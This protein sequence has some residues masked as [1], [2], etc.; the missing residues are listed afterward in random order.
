MLRICVLE[1]PS[2]QLFHMKALSILGLL[3][4]FT[5]SSFSAAAVTHYVDL[6]N[7]TPISPYTSWDTAATNI[8]HAI[9]IAVAGDLVLVTNGVYSSGTRAVYGLLL[10][11]V[12]IGKQVTVQ[13]VNGPEVTSI[14]AGYISS[15][16]RYVRGV[17]LGNGAVLSG[18][19]ISGGWATDG[20]P[21]GGDPVQEESGGGVLCEAAG[22]IVTNCIF[23]ENRAGNSGGAVYG[24]T[25]F[26]SLF[27]QNSASSGGGVYG[28]RVSD[29]LF[30]S[31]RVSASNSG[32]AAYGS[33]LTNCL[34]QANTAGR[35]A[36][37]YSS[38]FSNC[39][40][41][42]NIASISGGGAYLGSLL[43]CAVYGNSAGVSGGG[44]Y[45][46]V[47]TNC[48]IVSNVASNSAGGAY[49][50]QLKNSILYFNSAPS[51]ANYF[52]GSF[53]S[54]CTVPF[55]AAGLNNFTN[56]PQL[57][58]FTSLSSASPCIGAGDSSYARGTD[59]DGEEWLNP[60]S[61][62]CNEFNSGSL[63]GAVAVAINVNL[64]N[65]TIGHSVNFQA[66]IDGRVNAHFW[67]FGD[68]T[69]ISNSINNIH[70]WTSAGDFLVRLVA[71]NESNPLGV[72]SSVL[73]QVSSP[74]I[75]YVALNSAYP[76][77]PFTS[78]ATAATNIQ[79]AI[80]A[81]PHG[82][83]SVVVVSNGIYEFGARAVYGTMSNRVAVTKP[84]TVTSING[85]SVTIIRGIQVTGS[86]NGNTAIR[87]VYL[88]NGASLSG[89][90][91]TSGGTRAGGDLV[92]EQ[93]GGGLWMESTNVLVT[94][95]VI[96]GNSAA[97]FGGGAY[98]GHLSNCSLLENTGSLGGGA[99]SNLLENCFL[100]R[101]SAGSGGAVYSGTLKNCTVTGNYASTGGGINNCTAN[102]CIIYYNDALSGSD[103]V[104]GTLNYSCV[105][106]LPT[107]GVGNITSEPE[108]ASSS[109][110]S[111]KSPCRNAGT[112]A[113]AA[114]TDIDSQ[115]WADPPTM[116]CDEFYGGD[117]VGPL[118]LYLKAGFTNCAAGF[119]IGFVGDVMGNVSASRWEF[120]DG[121]I[122]S[123]RPYISHAWATPGDF[124][125][126]FRAYNSTYPNGLSATTMVHVVQPPVYHVAIDSSNP[127]APYLSWETAATNIQ[128][129][130]DLAVAGG[131]VLVSNG[132]Y[133]SGQRI[134]TGTPNRLAISAPLNVRSVNGP[135]VTILDGGGTVRCVYA[136]NYA[137]LTGFTI[138]NG[139]AGGGG[140]VWCESR[141]VVV[142]NC[143]VSGNSAGGGGGVVRGTLVN[144]VLSGNIATLGIGGGASGSALEGCI[145]SG[146]RADIIGGGV[147]YSTV[148]NSLIVDNSASPVGGGA[149]SS[150][151][152][153]S[154]VYYN[155]GGNHY[156]TTLNYCCTDPLPSGAGNFTSPPL[157]APGEYRL[158]SNS[159]CI[160]AGHNDFVTSVADFEG[161]SRIV[162]G[163]VDVGP[164]E[165]Q[166]PSSILSFAWAQQYGLPTDG[167]A[168]FADLDGD[169]MKNYGEWRSDTNPTNSLSV[170]RVLTATNAPTGISVTWQSVSTRN[171]WLERAV[172]LG[173]ATPFQIIATNITGSVGSKAFIDTSATNAGPYFFRV[174]VH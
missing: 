54:T 72:E 43:N 149:Y 109:H 25:I 2:D 12:V 124:P 79:D 132:V 49:N 174:G 113:F 5:A 29:C 73:I 84:V 21:F 94:N 118:T 80:D 28:S 159:P 55:P 22:S 41:V 143:I 133:N 87:G 71:F 154:I 122:V 116:G 4:L 129:A 153:N 7:P 8:Q 121:V 170:L 37:G 6:N 105:P 171:Y 31:N 40:I 106:I 152:N 102:N 103:W 164:Y 156:F 166:S 67:D 138:T 157:F 1:T 97:R 148:N 100:S 48:T 45:Q 52:N 17:Y 91:I 32:G 68:G 64:T 161:N 83:G 110:I 66:R 16:N 130:V 26:N 168:D 24:G 158:Q 111:E 81:A 98:S 128:D 160:N 63:T 53:A 78:W 123:N 38:T 10:N 88:T 150:V 165:F 33:G 142:S 126:V 144:C 145:V 70:S 9:D 139:T 95:C 114:G 134:I 147:A 108:L 23:L 146:N 58:S 119:V 167:S 34:L 117:I 172:A 74:T 62:G 101:N 69:I 50:A 82:F 135:D 77:P 15:Q 127:V 90:T 51:S 30:V 140:G 112:G 20:I 107:A 76:S 120:G 93:S 92:K 57:A 27:I 42:D 169:G 3:G 75:H 18:F 162:A 56:D 60:P 36:G 35:G 131:T 163:T 155:N 39:K 85:P 65:I 125:V 96:Y 104:G 59:I 136:T 115:V 47:A 19:T 141:S 173:L 99:A 44:I 89:F 13:S 11:R 151:I 46:S 137:T 86:T 14:T 61:I